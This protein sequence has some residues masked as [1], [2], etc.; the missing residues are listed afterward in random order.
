MWIWVTDRDLFIIK[1]RD[2]VERMVE[3]EYCWLNWM[4]KK[5]VMFD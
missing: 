5:E 2:M 4:G 1:N 3:V